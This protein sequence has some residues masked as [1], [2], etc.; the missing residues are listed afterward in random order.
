M[1]K[2][3]KA[4]QTVH[5]VELIWRETWTQGS[6][7]PLTATHVLAHL[8]PN[9][10]SFQISVSASKSKNLTLSQRQ[11]CALAEAGVGKP[12]SSEPLPCAQGPQVPPLLLSPRQLWLALTPHLSLLETKYILPF[13]QTRW[14]L[15]SSGKRRLGKAK[16]RPGGGPCLSSSPQLVQCSTYSECSRLPSKTPHQWSISATFKCLIKPGL[17]GHEVSTKSQGLFTS[18]RQKA[19]ALDCQAVQYA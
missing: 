12:V 14:F 17:L 11:G 5:L 15:D 10:P 16:Q 8:S 1:E 2:S 13:L 19:L 3:V 6:A 4:Y 18:K 7:L 9:S